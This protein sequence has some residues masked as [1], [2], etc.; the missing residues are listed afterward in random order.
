MNHRVFILAL[1]LILLS[2][3]ALNYHSNRLDKELQSKGILCGEISLIVQ[4]KERCDLI[5]RETIDIISLFDEGNTGNS[6]KE[7][8]FQKIDIDITSAL[9]PYFYLSL[10]PGLY[11]ENRRMIEKIL[12][13]YEKHGYCFW[14]LLLTR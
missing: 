10:N 14:K 7:T 1:C 8:K 2:G 5:H 11:D 13:Q 12:D 9:Y 3:C 4:G 6:S